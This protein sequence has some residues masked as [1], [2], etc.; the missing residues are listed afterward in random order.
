VRRV[1]LD[2]LFPPE[3]LVQEA[4]LFYLLSPTHALKTYNYF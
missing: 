4:H 3:R 1:V 2:R